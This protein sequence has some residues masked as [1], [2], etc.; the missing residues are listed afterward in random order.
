MTTFKSL[1]IDINESIHHDIVKNIQEEKLKEAILY[2]LQDGKRWRPIF[3][4]S[5]FQTSSIKIKE[6]PSLKSCYLFLEYVHNAS[7]VLDDLPM[8]DNDEY[9]RN[10]LTLHKKYSESTSKLAAL[11]LLLL[12][13]YNI[14]NLF[15]NLNK[16][17]YFNTIDELALFH[18][19]ITEIIYTYLGNNGLCLGQFLDLNMKLSE[20]KLE[21][22]HQMVNKKTSSLFSLSFVLG[23]IFSRKSLD[24]LDDIIKIGECFGYI[25][26]I[27]DDLEDYESDKNK[28]NNNNILFFTT[29]HNANLLI[30]QYYEQM[31]SL[32]N[33]YRL[34]CSIL[35]NIFKLLKSKWLKTKTKILL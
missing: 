29:R 6:F 33:Q 12:S 19:K 1:I 8:M 2:S 30:K 3:Y 22:W 27:L 17:G 4:L 31:I 23:Y 15:V 18:E 28:N 13:Q 7:L 32:I 16:E 20:K 34:G 11:Q 25:Y 9:R 5:V 24:N 10:K 26:Q 14:N 21:T 35:A